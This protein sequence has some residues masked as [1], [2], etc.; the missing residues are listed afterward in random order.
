MFLVPH[1]TNALIHRTNNFGWMLRGEELLSG[2]KRNVSV[3]DGLPCASGNYCFETFPHAVT[4]H[5]RG[6]NANAR[7]RRLSAPNYCAQ[8]E[9]SF[10]FPP[11]STLSTQALCALTAHLVA[12]GAEC[13]CFGDTQTGYI[14]VQRPEFLI[15]K[16]ITNLI[17]A[18]CIWSSASIDLR[19]DLEDPSGEARL[20]NVSAPSSRRARFLWPLLFVRKKCDSI[21]PANTFLSQGS[22]PAAVATGAIPNPI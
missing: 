3:V 18:G 1:T 9:S 14:V 16:W 21:V 2:L 12:S 11:A 13:Q 10:R 15:K 7:R 22:G 6:G 4:W 19:R 5:L 17:R 8:Q 20:T